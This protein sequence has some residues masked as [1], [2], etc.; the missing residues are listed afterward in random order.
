M[1]KTMMV[2]GQERYLLKCSFHTHFAETYGNS[3]EIMVDAYYKA[4]YDCIA[5]TE[6]DDVIKDLE[7][8]KRAQLYAKKKYGSDFL[9]IV[10][11]ELAF[12]DRNNSG[13][14]VREVLGLFLSEYI[15]TGRKKQTDYGS[16][17]DGQKALNEIHRQGGIAIICHDN[18]I[19]WYL[20]CLGLGKQAWMWDFRHR[21]PIDGW[22]VGN[23]IA[24]LEKKADRELML[25]HPQESVDERYIVLA[26]SDAHRI[27]EIEPCGICYTYVFANQRTLDE[28][29][30]AL[31]DRRT[32]AYC[33]GMMYGTGR[34]VCLLQKHHNV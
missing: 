1:K 11:E 15:L 6:H 21:L 31:L 22:E 12:S 2:D 10:G 34:L 14:D 33:N 17:I 5:L 3:A 19:I 7:G 30:E 20:E 9:V 13:C 4:G 23:G 28:V 26:S 32:V 16:L 25:S 24:A 27:E 18:W 8:E 29:K